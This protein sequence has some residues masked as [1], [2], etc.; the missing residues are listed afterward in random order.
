MLY[1]TYTGC[2]SIAHLDEKVEFKSV[3]ESPNQQGTAE[4]KCLKH[5]TVVCSSLIHVYVFTVAV[6]YLIADSE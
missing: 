5:T 3:V 1:S 6:L 4:K 2:R